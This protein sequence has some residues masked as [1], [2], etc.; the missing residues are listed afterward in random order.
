MKDIPSVRY[1]AIIWNYTCVTSRST[2]AIRQV[3]SSST[4][5]VW[6]RAPSLGTV[7]PEVPKI[8]S[9]AVLW[10]AVALLLYAALL[11]VS[12]FTFGLALQLQKRNIVCQACETTPVL[13]NASTSPSLF[14]IAGPGAALSSSLWTCHSQLPQ[15]FES[16]R[17]AGMSCD[18]F[19]MR[20]NHGRV[21]LYSF[22]I[23]IANVRRL[24]GNTMI[25]LFSKPRFITVSNSYRA[26]T[27][28]VLDPQLTVL[29]RGLCAPLDGRFRL[30]FIP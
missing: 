26:V 11:E 14:S 20:K 19:V 13:Y 15:A 6:A 27:G 16:S 9:P 12:L 29:N 28:T 10:P 30:Q 25:T 8:L 17:N 22:L 18:G 24:S 3:G 23:F 4:N 7:F 2:Q 21:Q 1:F 5:P